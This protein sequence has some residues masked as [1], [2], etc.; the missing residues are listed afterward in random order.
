MSVVGRTADMFWKCRH[1][2]FWTRNGLQQSQT[3]SV[4]GLPGLIEA[5][6]VQKIGQNTFS[7]GQMR[8]RQFIGLI[9]GATAWPLAARGQQKARYPTIGV[10]GPAKRT[11]R[12][13]GGC[14]SLL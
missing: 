3:F 2:R 13:H 4:S 7:V 11:A 9:G 6:M 5:A 14:L 8:R 1:F 10:V 12:K